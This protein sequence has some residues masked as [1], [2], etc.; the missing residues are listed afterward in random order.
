MLRSFKSF[1]NE[2]Y[3]ASVASGT[4]DINDQATVTNIN[5]MLLGALKQ[6]FIT[7]YIAIERVRKV[8][9]NFAIHLEGTT[10]MFDEE[11]DKTFDILQF[12]GVVGAS[13][14]NA[15]PDFTGKVPDAF[16]YFAWEMND[17]GAYDVWCQLVDSEELEELLSDNDE[18][19]ELESEEI[20]GVD[21]IESE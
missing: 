3:Q 9:A 5:S 15:A 1:L 14:D 21:P 12:G 4:V 19:D 6:E 17:N 16:I 8:L 13:P 18:D 20:A 11:G 10:D 7:P 2:D